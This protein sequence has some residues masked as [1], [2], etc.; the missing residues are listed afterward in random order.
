MGAATLLRLL[1]T[2]PI[3]FKTLLQYW[4]YHQP[5]RDITAKTEHKTSGY[6]RETMR[7][8][9]ELLDHSS[10]SFASVIK[11]VDGDLA[12][13][14]CLF[15]IVLRALDTVEDD[16]TIPEDVKQPILRSFHEK[17]VTPGWHFT[18]S[19][20]DEKDRVVLV[21]YANVVEEVLRIDPE[22]R[23]V[24][25]DIARKM[26]TG[27]ADFA[28]NA[29]SKGVLSL[30]TIA[31]YDLYCHYVAG[32]VG[33]GLSRLFAATGKEAASIA[34]QLELANSTG[35][36]LQKT[37]II[38]DFR[39]DSDERRFFWPREIWG[40][41][42]YGAG[43]PAK[44][45]TQLLAPGEEK[46]AAWAQSGMIVDALRHATDALD[47][48]RLLRNQSVFNFVAIP[49]TMAMATLDL[50]FMNPAMFQR[51]IKIR[52]ATAAQ[53]IMQS[54]NPRE[55]A[56]IFRD[57]ARS[58]HRRADPADPNFLRISVA[59]ARI[60][61]WAE[62]Q[63]PSFVLLTARSSSLGGSGAAFS[64]TDARSRVAQLELD[65][66]NERADEK[67]R[68]ELQERF[69][70]RIGGGVPTPARPKAVQTAPLEFFFFVA[71][72]V[73]TILGLSFGIVWF[74]LAY[75]PE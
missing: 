35:L 47:Y 73:L 20:P 52:K 59:C 34:T 69:G 57:Y 14:I 56:C 65:I 67:R 28:H 48:C 66:E 70:A 72:L 61:Q 40:R 63:Y 58:I 45:V 3:E 31:D 54:T 9:W 18:G 44:D 4:A 55:V 42:E 36:M 19:G 68:L 38:R 26:G 62:H 7:K 15:Y 46:R 41:A 74:I 75:F 71:L 27:M 22:A 6:D 43:V 1:I 37:N 10:R 53:L 29:A 39:E 5:S 25:V 24:I 11:E 23:D 60:E 13:V 32:L 12:R 33:E 51:N 21:E 16:M 50:C 17:T 64:G 49:L 2:H 8:C 30:D